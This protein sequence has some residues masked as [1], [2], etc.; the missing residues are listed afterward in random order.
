M[1]ES[2]MASAGKLVA[3]ASAPSLAAGSAKA[4]AVAAAA[5]SS[6]QPTMDGALPMDD[7][8]RAFIAVRNQSL[9]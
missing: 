6:S 8:V 2:I 5:A 4:A 7:K 1:L 3:T 9:K